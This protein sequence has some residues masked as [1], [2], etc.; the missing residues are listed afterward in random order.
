[1]FLCTERNK[2]GRERGGGGGRTKQ[3]GPKMGIKLNI[4]Q[5]YGQI[6]NYSTVTTNIEKECCVISL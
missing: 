6:P 5:S 3:I 1:M 4:A 2:Q